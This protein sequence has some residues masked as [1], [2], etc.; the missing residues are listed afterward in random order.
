M[1]VCFRTVVQDPSDFVRVVQSSRLRFPEVPRF[2]DR[3]DR[4]VGPIG[5]GSHLVVNLDSVEVLP[6][7]RD[8]VAADRFLII[9]PCWTTD[10][11]DVFD[12]VVRPCQVL[13]EGITDDGRPRGVESVR[14]F[15]IK[16]S[17]FGRVFPRGR[18]QRDSNDSP[19]DLLASV[20]FP[21][22]H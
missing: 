20:G 6:C 3:V 13:V 8:V 22:L 2:I 11:D 17:Q 19:L 12:C 15:V 1:R 5:G 14:P 9:G 4:E 7:R 21:R 18:T 10:P 16:V